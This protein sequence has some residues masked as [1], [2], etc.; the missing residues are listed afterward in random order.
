M[1]KIEILKPYNLLLIRYGEI[2]LKSQKIKVRMLKRLIENIKI[3][4]KINE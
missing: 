1:E 2:W 3:L 4:L